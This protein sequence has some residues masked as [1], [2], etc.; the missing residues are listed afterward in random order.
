MTTAPANQETGARHDESLYERAKRG[1]PESSPLVQFPNAPLLIAIG[2]LVL[3]ALTSGTVGRA[4]LAAAYAALAAWAWLEVTDGA[5]WPRRLLG[6]VALVAVVA[7][8]ADA[9]AS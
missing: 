3:A 6:A 5:G 9:L 4:A 8:V 2:A 7:R 1:W